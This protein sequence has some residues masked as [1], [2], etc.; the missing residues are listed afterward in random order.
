MRC[1]DIVAFVY[2]YLDGEFDC[3]ERAEFEAHLATCPSCR[4]RVEI[5]SWFLAQVRKEAANMPKA[6][7]WLR[8][9]IHE[10]LCKAP[11]GTKARGWLPALPGYVWKPLPLIASLGALAFF[12]WPLMGTSI[13]PMVE[14]LVAN[15]KKEI[16]IDVAGPEPSRI[17]RFYSNRLP[18]TLSLPRFP[19]EHSNMLGARVMQFSNR[20]SAE[21]IY[22]VDGE[23]VTLVV[24]QGA[25]FWKQQPSPPDRHW[26][27]R[28]ASG[29]NVALHRSSGLTYGITSKMARPRLER[30]VHQASFAP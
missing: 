25:G 17:Q 21:V 30:I 14:E 22:D 28:H 18:F 11:K 6:P 26:V 24:F 4:R 5:E 8:S 19:G 2:P 9:R 20:P 15:H 12:I 27:L 23:K 1:E 7:P 3:Q 10:E 16:L 29:Y 13:D